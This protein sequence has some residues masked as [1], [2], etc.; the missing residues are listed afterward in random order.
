MTKFYPP[1]AAVPDSLDGD[2]FALRPLTVDHV[3][4]DYA[5]LMASRPMLRLWS[6]SSWPADDFSLA[7]NEKDLAHHQREHEQRLAFTYTVLDPSG[8]A[9]LGCVY[10]IPNHF[11]VLEPRDGDALVS[12]WVTE[13][14]VSAGLDARLLTV[15]RPWL[16]DSFAFGRI[17][18]LAAAAYAH[19]VDLFTAAG[20]AQVGAIDRQRRRGRYLVFTELA[21]PNGVE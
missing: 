17:F 20:L 10:I 12:Y 14:H 21:L 2:G 15:M 11:E 5:A 7:D 4:L 19:Q 9:C 1:V 8:S 3:A 13:L 6:G 18:W 16:A